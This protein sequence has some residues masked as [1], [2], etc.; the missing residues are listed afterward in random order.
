MQ[1]EVHLFQMQQSKDHYLP[2]ICDVLGQNDPILSSIIF[3]NISYESC[4]YVNVECYPRLKRVYAE[5]VAPA[6]CPEYI[7]ITTSF[8]SF[9]SVFSSL[10][11]LSTYS[12]GG[13]MV[14]GNNSTTA[15]GGEGES[16]HVQFLVSIPSAIYIIPSFRV[17]HQL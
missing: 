4:M 15:T 13:K 12:R 2:I 5:V 7:M 3:L 10:D 8:Y 11:L 1:V 17:L 16:L 9:S 14:M 6:Y